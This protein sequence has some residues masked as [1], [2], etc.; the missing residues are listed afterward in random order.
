MFSES[1]SFWRHIGHLLSGL[2][3]SKVGRLIGGEVAE[4]QVSNDKKHSMDQKHDSP[5]GQSIV[6]AEQVYEK[7]LDEQGEALDELDLRKDKV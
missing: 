2:V 4:D 5:L 1:S 6:G 3:M 7:R